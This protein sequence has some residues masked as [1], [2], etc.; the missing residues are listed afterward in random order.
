M[1]VDRAGTAT[2]PERGFHAAAG[3]MQRTAFA[4]RPTE[5]GHPAIWAP[6]PREPSG[7]AVAK[8]LQSPGDLHGRADCAR[9]LRSLAYAAD[10]DRTASVDHCRD[11]CRGAGFERCRLCLLRHLRRHALS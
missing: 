4:D 8:T 9:R 3:E 10:A 5:P 1:P 2:N 11:F 6:R 7:A